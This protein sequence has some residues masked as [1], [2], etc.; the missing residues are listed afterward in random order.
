MD[1][2]IACL[3]PWEGFNVLYDGKVKCCCWSY[4]VTGR[5]DRQSIAEIW[6]SDEFT[7]VRELMAKGNLETIC[8]S[9]C[10]RLLDGSHDSRPSNGISD[11]YNQNLASLDDE[12]G[13]VQLTARPIYF[14]IFPTSRCNLHCIMCGQDHSQ[15]PDFP[16]HFQDELIRYYP[17]IRTILAAGGEPLMS[18]DFR[19]LVK[20]FDYN[21]FPD[22]KFRIISNG[23]LLDN[24]FLYLLSGRFDQVG[25]SIDSIDPQKF[26]QIRQGA[27]WD[28]V[29]RIIERIAGMPER[30]FSL[31]LL[32]T[33]MKTNYQEIPAFVDF[34]RNLGAIPSLNPVLDEW[35]GQQIDAHDRNTVLEIL[36]QIEPTK[37]DNLLGTRKFFEDMPTEIRNSSE[38]QAL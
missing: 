29:S 14:R 23:T 25:I 6:N 16:K 37:V 8:P 1:K 22:C 26:E 38:R 17:Y 3:M 4:A 30:N 7:K 31:H 12:I 15:F 32:F 11:A 19:E 35:H 5:I 10:P 24:N 2:K 9:W 33:I 34:A 36:N 27:K 20:N 21:R 13:Q 28:N 18:K